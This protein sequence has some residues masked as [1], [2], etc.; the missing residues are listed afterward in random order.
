MVE[1]SSDA[2]CERVPYLPIG[3][4]DEEQPSRQSVTMAHHEGGVSAVWLGAAIAAT[5]VAVTLLVVAVRIST[6][7]VSRDRVSCGSVVKPIDIEEIGPPGT[8]PHP[9]SNAHDADTAV[10]VVLLIAASG[11]VIAVVRTRPGRTARSAI[12]G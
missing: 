2:T 11:L 3:V 5:L 1:K 6:R 8:N 7:G 9:C 12:V 4:F 10:A